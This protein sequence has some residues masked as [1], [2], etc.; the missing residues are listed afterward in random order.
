MLHKLKTCKIY[1]DLGA[2]PGKDRIPREAALAGCVVI[3]NKLGAADNEVDIPIEEKVDGPEELKVLIEDI[4]KNYESY[5]EKQKNYRD[6]IVN[7]KDIF[8]SQV[9]TF[10]AY[11]ANN[12]K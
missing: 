8:K 1:V 3:T 4:F 12:D 7:E 9:K 2:H 10:I 11:L 6:I 5:Y